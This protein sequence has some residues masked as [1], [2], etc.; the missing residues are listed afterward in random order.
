MT[1]YRSMVLDSIYASPQTDRWPTTPDRTPPAPRPAIALPSIKAI[2]VGAAAQSAEPVSNMTMD[3]KN[4][5][6]MLRNLYSFPKT[7][8]NAQLVS[9]YA[10]PYQ[11]TSS[12]ELKV[13]VIWGIAVD[14]M[15]LSCRYLSDQFRCSPLLSLRSLGGQLTRDTRNIA[16]NMDSISNTNLSPEG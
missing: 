8:W 16:A 12:C 13:F 15:S 4:V 9:R 10:V 6:L 11:P 7:S 5:A 14:M 2:E 1:I 3:V